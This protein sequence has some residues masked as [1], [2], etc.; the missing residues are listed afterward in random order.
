[1]REEEDCLDRIDYY[2][3]KAKDLI[4]QIKTQLES[5]RSFNFLRGGREWNLSVVFII[6]C[7]FQ[8]CKTIPGPLTAI[9][10]LFHRCHGALAF[11]CACVKFLAGTQL[12]HLLP[13]FFFF[14]RGFKG[15]ISFSFSES[16]SASAGQPGNWCR[17]SAADKIK[18]AFA[19]RRWL[20]KN[21]T[22]TTTNFCPWRH[23]RCLLLVGLVCLRG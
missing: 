8:P 18:A 22:K 2:L 13:C 15:N 12:H 20:L 11:H 23:K 19:R 14:Y 21:K 5:R 16:S 17:A 4:F 3:R 10:L 9:K 7:H 1:M 6:V